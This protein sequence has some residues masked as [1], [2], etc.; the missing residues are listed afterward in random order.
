MRPISKVPFPATPDGENYKRLHGRLNQI[1]QYMV[2]HYDYE[3]INNKGTYART[4]L[5]VDWGWTREVLIDFLPDKDDQFIRL[6]IYAGETKGQGWPLYGKQIDF[7]QLPESLGEGEL[8]L[9]PYLK[10]R[11]F[12]SPV[13]VLYLEKDEMTQT[14]N[15]EFHKKHAGKY[16]RVG[17]DEFEN[18]LTSIIPG[19]RSRCPE[20]E[21]EVRGSQRSYFTFSAG[22]ILE[23]RISYKKLR[24]VDK[25]EVKLIAKFFQDHIESLRALIDQPYS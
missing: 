15:L 10:F 11:H 9:K 22:V 21:S 19:W 18:T 3:E 17:W 14:H 5:G 24:A 7:S 23:L 4:S 2:E 20:Y 6:A 25:G 8:V 16:K 1:K 12:S 13:A